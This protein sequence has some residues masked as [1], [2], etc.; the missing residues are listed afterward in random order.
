MGETNQLLER[1]RFETKNREQRSRER[2]ESDGELK[3]EAHTS[4]ALSSALNPSRNPLILLRTRK[5]ALQ[6]LWQG[7]TL[8][9]SEL[10]WLY[11]SLSR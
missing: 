2:T 11:A 1:D 9:P 7:E 5:A 6:G 10:G 8:C 4:T 3:T